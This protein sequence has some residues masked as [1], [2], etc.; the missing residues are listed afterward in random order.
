MQLA[1]KGNSLA[2]SNT[3]WS[4]L[5]P[6]DR[7]IP[8][9][10]LLD[11]DEALK[12]VTVKGTSLPVM[13]ELGENNQVTP[14]NRWKEGRPLIKARKELV[15]DEHPKTPWRTEGTGSQN[16]LCYETKQSFD[17]LT[18]NWEKLPPLPTRW[19]M[20]PVI[21]AKLVALPV[22][23]AIPTLR[24]MTLPLTFF[25]LR[26]L[27]FALGGVETLYDCL[28][29]FRDG[30]KTTQDADSMSERAV[31]LEAKTLPVLTSIAST[32]NTA[33]SNGLGH[34]DIHEVAANG[35]VEIFKSL[36]NSDHTLVNAK[37][38]SH[39][40]PLHL[41]ASEGKQALVELL[42]ANNVDVNAKDWQ[43]ATPLVLAIKNGHKST[44]DLLRQH[45]AKE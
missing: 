26:V 30:Q 3:L 5:L 13:P 43:G 37:N 21:L 39:L 8:K 2:N 29:Q 1:K 19:H 22:Q 27:P 20:A 34:L 18:L 7:Q 16:Y 33:N 42:L 25:D 12:V 40:T 15:V 14:A 38:N 17:V 4:K 10:L 31:A 6:S 35:D 41:A 45:G 44:A 36:V 32:G 28:R 9:T 24:T 23:L 11:P